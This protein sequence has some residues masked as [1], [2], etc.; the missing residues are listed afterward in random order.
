[1]AVFEQR[2]QTLIQSVGE[3]FR[4]VPCRWNDGNTIGGNTIK[5]RKGFLH[6][7][8]INGVAFMDWRSDGMLATLLV[9]I[10]LNS[11]GQHQTESIPHLK[12]ILS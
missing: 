12:I 11:F 6:C 2:Y 9:A 4:R 10:P 8:A 3:F 7:V 5:D 1:M